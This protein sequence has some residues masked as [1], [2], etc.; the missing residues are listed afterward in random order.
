M[1]VDVGFQKYT[2]RNVQFTH[3][4]IQI[5]PDLKGITL[6]LVNSTMLQQL[7]QSGVAYRD[8]KVLY[9]ICI[10]VKIYVHMNSKHIHTRRLNHYLDKKM[11]M[12][13][14][15]SIHRVQF[16]ENIKHF[17]TRNDKEKVIRWNL[18]AI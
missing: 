11:E 5:I 12:K 17:S 16:V 9:D 2:R 14:K 18:D 15:I 8:F 3:K 1:D 6:K 4:D 7:R 13:R 10:S